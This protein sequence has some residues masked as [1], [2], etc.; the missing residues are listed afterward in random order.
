[1]LMRRGIKDLHPRPRLSQIEE[2]AIRAAFSSYHSRGKEPNAP[3]VLLLCCVE[4]VRVISHASR[5]KKIIWS[6]RGHEAVIRTLLLECVMC[7]IPARVYHF[8]CPPA[9]QMRSVIKTFNKIKC[10]LSQCDEFVTAGEGSC[11]LP[12]PAAKTC[13]L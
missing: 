6:A 12:P 11:K 9:L 3:R 5:R 1:M 7:V 4:C 10:L 2:S 13:N 8:S